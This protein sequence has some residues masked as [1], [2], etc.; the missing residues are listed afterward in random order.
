MHIAA[1]T[2][3]CMLEKM[4]TQLTWSCMVVCQLVQLSSVPVSKFNGHMLP[5]VGET[6]E[7][8]F[9][10]YLIPETLSI[11]TMGRRQEGDILNLEIEAQTQVE[12]CVACVVTEPCQILVSS[13]IQMTQG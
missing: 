10:I 12:W 5:Q 7:D 6:G 13:C 4:P 3:I 11:T 9:C 2:D 8:W 1:F